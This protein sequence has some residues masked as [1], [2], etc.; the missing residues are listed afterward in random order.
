MGCINDTQAALK[1]LE[2][3]IFMTILKLAE[4]FN[5]MNNEQVFNLC[6]QGLKSIYL[7]VWKLCAFRQRR[8]YGNFQ[9]FFHHNV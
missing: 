5:S 9:Q 7:I 2:I 6:Y 8:Y 1:S 4:S 3:Y